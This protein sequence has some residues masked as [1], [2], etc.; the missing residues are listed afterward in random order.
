[1][2]PWEQSGFQVYAG[3]SISGADEDARLFLGRYLKKSPES[4]ERI[5]SKIPCDRTGEGYVGRA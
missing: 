3:E 5:H 1:M 2:K 4:L